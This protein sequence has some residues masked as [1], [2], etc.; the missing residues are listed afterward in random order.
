MPTRRGW[1]LAVAVAV[2]VLG[3]LGAFTFGYGEG[4]SYLTDDPRACANCHVMQGHFDAWVAS[5]HGAVATCGDCHLER[6]FVGKWIT[7]AENGFLHALAF[8]TGDFHEPIRIRPRN[9]R[10]TER[11]CRDCHR[12]LVHA[13]APG[14]PAREPP[15]CVRC[16]G[17]VGHA[18]R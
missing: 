12:S 3:G 16:H 14:E 7:K 1:A 15:G 4:F 17:P 10:V 18:L 2:G 8:T 6:S 13:M 5:S 11:A 9:R